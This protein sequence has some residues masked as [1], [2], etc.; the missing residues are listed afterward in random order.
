[1]K[2]DSI[3]FGNFNSFEDVYE[4]T[5]LVGDEYQEEFSQFQQDFKIKEYSDEAICQIFYKKATNDIR[6]LLMGNPGDYQ[7]IKQLENLA[8]EKNYNTVIIYGG[9]D[10]QK[11]RETTGL[12]KI[13]DIAS[14]NYELDFIGTLHFDYKDAIKKYPKT[15]SEYGDL[16]YQK[17]K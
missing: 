6:Q 10:Y 7:Y 3:W 13:T 15:L 8:I 14:S 12:K 9:Y 16:E 11:E 5:S 17:K 2:Y 1:M 4:Y